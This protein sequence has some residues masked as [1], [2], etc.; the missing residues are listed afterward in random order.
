MRRNFEQTKEE[1]E[2]EKETFEF[3]YKVIGKKSGAKSE[4]VKQG[5]G[6]W[7]VISSLTAKKGYVHE[8]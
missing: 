4:I 6:N 2:E 1:E 3:E 7:S 8:S 5:S